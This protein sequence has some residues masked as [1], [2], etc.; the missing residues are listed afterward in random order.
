MYRCIGQVYLIFGI[1]ALR[2]PG[3][4]PDGMKAQQLKP[5]EADLKLIYW[6]GT[7]VRNVV[8]NH[9]I[10]LAIGRGPDFYL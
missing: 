2:I 9:Q 5:F 3:T 6:F 7:S 1:R 10:K 8:S 4:E